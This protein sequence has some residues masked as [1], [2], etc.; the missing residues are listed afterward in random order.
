MQT[1]AQL[2]PDLVETD[3]QETKDRQFVMMQDASLK[4]QA[5]INKSP[6]DLNLDQLKGI[7]IFENDCQTNISSFQDYLSQA[8]ELGHKVLIEN[9]NSEKDSTD[10]MNRFLARYPAKLKIYGH[11]IQSLE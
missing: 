6:Q 2:K 3:V 9:K 4:D 1:T 5:R 8:N 11:Q 10:M 7:E